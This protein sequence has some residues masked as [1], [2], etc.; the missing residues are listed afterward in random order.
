MIYIKKNKNND[1]VRCLY[2]MLVI[3]PLN[4]MLN[5]LFSL[6]NEN[7]NIL[8]I[9]Y[10]FVLLY[11]LYV[12]I[13]YSFT[14]K[15]IFAILF[16]YLLYGILYLLSTNS[17]KI[18]MFSTYMR[19]IYIYFIPLSVIIISHIEDL[20]AL[21]TNRYVLISDFII[22][23]SLICKLFLK[24]NT[25][26]M[27]FSYDLLPLWGIITISAIYY[28]KNMQKLIVCT[29][30]FEALIFGCRGALIWLVSC[31][32]LVYLFKTIYNKNL[33]KLKKTLV[34]LPFFI[35][36][37]IGTMIKVVPK[38]LSSRYASSSYILTRLTMGNLSESNARSKI[39][40]ICLENLKH[41]GFNINGLF[42]DRSILPNGMYTHNI[43]IEIYLSLGWIIGTIFILFII[44]IILSA[45]KKQSLEGKVILIYFMSVLFFRYFIS[46]SIFGEGKFIIFLSSCIALKK[47]I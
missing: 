35:F 8:L 46:G 6:N 19:L 43:L 33:K 11:G 40:Q 1:R 14:K 12:I 27:D 30:F 23:L 13:R 18:E 9:M 37:V 4:N 41:M 25:D 17:G 20:S 28:E 34:I 38:L 42:Y 29:I 45:F 2:L 16:I 22:F 39:I 21:F 10:F 3:Y 44:K 47:I 36:T 5:T 24:D 15:D 26:Y 7:N 32:L 31:G